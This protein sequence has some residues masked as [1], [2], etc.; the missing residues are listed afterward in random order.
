MHFFWLDFESIL[1]QFKGLPISDLVPTP[2]G[3]TRKSV[4]GE[5]LEIDKKLR[6]KEVHYPRLPDLILEWVL[7]N[8]AKFC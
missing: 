7:K 3:S 4:I 1:N 8:L 6:Q 2:V 5:T